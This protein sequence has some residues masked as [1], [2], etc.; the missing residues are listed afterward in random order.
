[1]KPIKVFH[2]GERLKDIYPHATK[3]QVFKFRVRQFIHKALQITAIG[4]TVFVVATIAFLTGHETQ[5]SVV[6]AATVDSLPAKVQSLQLGVV[7]QIE[8]CES[9]GLTENDGAIILDTNDK[10]SIGQLMFQKQTVIT[11]EKELYNVTMTPKD[12]VIVA[13]TTPEAESLAQDIIFKTKNGLSNWYNCSQ[14]YDLQSQ[15]DII[16]KLNTN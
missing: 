6:S 2:N 4:A 5:T 16:N 7:K 11:Y 3:W 12:A 13:L 10:M 9:K 14:K 8:S 15:V 1:M